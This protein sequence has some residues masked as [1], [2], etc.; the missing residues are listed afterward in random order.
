MAPRTELG[1]ADLSDDQL[2]SFVAEALGVERV[3]LLS[4]QVQA[5]DYDLEALTTA[6]RY[7]IRGRARHDG[8]DEPYAF[9]VKVVQ[10]WTRTP[11]FQFVPEHLREQ[12]GLAL[13]W[14][15]EVDVYRSDLASLLPDGL[16]LPRVHHV[17]D[18]DDLSAFFW[19]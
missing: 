8:G 1:P 13:P 15:G 6:G 2:A 9:F 12:A 19:L 3:E 7:W 18:I 14:R 10:S 17:G 16:A 5:V 4:A 11:Q